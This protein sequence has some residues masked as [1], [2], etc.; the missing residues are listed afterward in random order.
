MTS[1][2]TALRSVLAVAAT[3]LNKNR[4]FERGEI[5]QKPSQ[6]INSETVLFTEIGFPGYF[7]H[8]LI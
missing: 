7:Y 3:D 1:W 4:M 2:A 5:A 6:T 8:R